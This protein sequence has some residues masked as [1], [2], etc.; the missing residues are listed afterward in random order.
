MGRAD[1]EGP[2]ALAGRVGP[3]DRV[4]LVALVG[5]ADR[6]RPATP[7]RTKRLI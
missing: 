3:A 2:V 1:R 7:E 6:A 4:A 5:P